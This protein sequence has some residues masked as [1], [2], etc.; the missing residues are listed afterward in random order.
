MAALYCACDALVHPFR[1]EGFGLPIVEAMACGLPV[2]VTG[3]GPA[4]DYAS[5]KTAYFIPAE[6]RPL[7]DGT[8]DGMETIG[9]PWL[10]EPDA[11]AL[12]ELLKRVVSDRDG[13]RAIGMAASDHIREHFTWAR[14]VEAVEQRLRALTP[15]PMRTAEPEAPVERASTCV[16]DPATNP[17]RGESVSTAA[18]SSAGHEPGERLVDDDREKR[19]GKPSAVLSFGRRES[20]TRSSSS[21]P[22]ARIGPRRSLASL[23]RRCLISSGS[24][25]SRRRGTRR[26]RMRPVIMRFGLMP[27]MSLSRSERE[28][29]L[30][31][32]AG[33][34]RPSIGRNWR[35]ARC[36][37]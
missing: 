7:G 18:A 1:G 17:K 20:S 26:F 32:L 16:V 14:T 35:A 37:R 19:G 24:I 21:T 22:A 23:G 34:K 30:A 27:M 28:K 13:A 25:A 5:D 9:Q 2:I 33:L 3:A 6:R 36:C 12:V 8:V 11:D 10:F 31:L 15:G 4:L 29:L